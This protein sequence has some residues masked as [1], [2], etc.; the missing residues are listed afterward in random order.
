MMKK[1]KEP[2]CSFCKES[3]KEPVLTVESVVLEYSIAAGSAKVIPP[4]SSGSVKEE[5]E[6]GADD[7]RTIEW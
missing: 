5:W 4:D 1:S 6:T 2:E 3:Y 7:N